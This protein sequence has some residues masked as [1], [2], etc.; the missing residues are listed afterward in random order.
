MP[1]AIKHPLF[2]IWSNMRAKAKRED[3]PICDQW[4][5]FMAFA[6][7]MGERPHNH[8][9]GRRNDRKG[10]EP[11]NCLW[12]T[13]RDLLR[14]TMAMVTI[15]GQSYT[16][17]ELAEQAGISPHTIINRVNAGLSFVEVMASEPRKKPRQGKTHCPYGH[18]YTVENS[19]VHSNGALTCRTCRNERDR[20]RR[21]NK[22]GLRGDALYKLWTNM[23]SRCASPKDKD[24]PRYGGRGIK[25]C[26][27]WSSFEA[28]KSDMGPRP[29]G[30]T[31]ER[32]NNDGDYE[33]NNCKWETR[34]EQRRNR[35]N[36]A[37]VT[38]DGITYKAIELAEQHGIDRNTI[39]HRIKLGMSLAEVVSKERFKPG[40]KRLKARSLTSILKG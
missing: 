35:S 37:Y 12:I 19:I 36:T 16:A 13:R 31:I 30:Y 38:I 6:H 1:Y 24:W 17:K 34:K 4:G 10:F 32:I 18:E 26:E 7:D 14:D 33:P 29:D 20:F 22:I 39:Y 28:F 11:G 23:R 15:E 8:I 2:D 25:C 27:R 21:A 5:S 40:R 3:I 9:L